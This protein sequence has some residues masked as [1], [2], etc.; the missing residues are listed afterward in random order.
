MT[1]EK[2]NIFPAANIISLFDKNL[3]P[4]GEHH[5]LAASPFQK[6]ENL[7]AGITPRQSILSL[8]LGE[9]DGGLPDIVKP[10]LNQPDFFDGFGKYPEL[11]G[12]VDFRQAV[13]NW[14]ERRFH[15]RPG[16]LAITPPHNNIL[17][18]TGSREGLALAITYAVKKKQPQCKNKLPVVVITS[19]FYH[20]Y[21][22][23]GVIAGA[24]VV[25]IHCYDETA[26]DKNH[27]A[28]NLSL[29]AGINSLPADV[30]QRLAAVVVCTPDNPTGRV[31][32]M[33]EMEHLHDVTAA[34]DAMLI[35][36]ECYSD[37]HYGI[38]PISFLNH[39]DN[40]FGWRGVI[41]SNSLSKR[42][43]APGLRSGILLA[44]AAV[45]KELAT[46]R[47]HLSAIHPRSLQ[48]IATALWNDDDHVAANRAKY[49]A[50]LKTAS[51][52][53][54]HSPSFQ[55]PSAGFFLYL[56]FNNGAEA[57][58]QI[59]AETGIKLLPAVFMAGGEAS[60]KKNPASPYARLAMIIGG[61]EWRDALAR[62][63]PFLLPTS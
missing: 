41:I 49:Q 4:H 52:V 24:D 22:A 27:A 57:V 34:H 53:I 54:G 55:M 8:H 48:L 5:L 47:A 45:V 43:G 61:D 58:K 14:A 46:L 30:K 1:K 28:K 23:A 62:L 51:E 12:S 6:L 33:T 15:L 11:L 16:L 7:L 63:K 40:G 25:A 26:I 37:L 32:T 18:T 31:L 9:P 29:A 56:R 2:G 44:D 42:S 17:P 19:P 13:K 39:V 36:D 35:S 50:R 60:D 3:A 38:P 21:H 20:V 59:F 10:I